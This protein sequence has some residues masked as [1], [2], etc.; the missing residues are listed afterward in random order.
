MKKLRSFIVCIGLLTSQFVAS[1]QLN[2]MFLVADPDGSGVYTV[3]NN[4]DYRIFINTALSELKI[5]DGNIE[6]APY[7][8]ENLLD[9]KINI[10]PSRAIIEP[11]FE[12]DFR[13]TMQCEGE[14]Q[15]PK[16]E[17]F[18]VTF[19]PSPYFEDEE[20]QNNVQV[21]IGFGAIFLVPGESSDINFEAKH[22]GDSVQVSNNQ[23][24]FLTAT[25]SVCEETQSPDCTQRFHILGGRTLELALQEQLVDKPLSIELTTHD[26]AHRA[27][28]LPVGGSAQ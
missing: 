27:Y 7:S 24:N 12:K 3:S 14:C 17:V 1:M 10:R 21:V 23:L 8:R 22:R 18:K 9:W 5:A 13:V 2:T 15:L 26:G 6:Y 4:S 28:Q 25:L 16:D 19:I 20:E 11:G